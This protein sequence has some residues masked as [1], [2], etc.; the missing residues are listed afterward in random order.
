MAVP[1]VLAALA[2][3]A[4]Q[5]VRVALVDSADSAGPVA[6]QVEWV[7]QTVQAV[8]LAAEVVAEIAVNR[9][10]LVAL[11]VLAQKADPKK[12]QL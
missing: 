5:A 4:D 10:D 6:F 9:A 2:E 11:G 7:G 1:A 8:D 12:Q 3:M